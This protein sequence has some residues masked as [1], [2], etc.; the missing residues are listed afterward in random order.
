M[1][2]DITPKGGILIQDKK[3]KKVFSS[4]RE[5]NTYIDG[6]G[7]DITV[8]D[9]KGGW[10]LPGLIDSHSHI[11]ITEDKIGE[12]GNDCNE[13]VDPITPY[14]SALDG[15]NPM[16]HAFDSAIRAG[17]T[18]V[19]V[20]P[21]S[22]NVVGGQFVFIKTYGTVVD[23][24]VVLAPAAMK[25]AFGE[26]PK[27]N[28]ARLDKSPIT[29]MATAAILRGEIIKAIQY[30]EK[31]EHAKAEEKEFSID[32]RYEC[33]IPVLEKKIPLK[34]HAHR[35]DDILTAIRIAK[36]FDLDM[37]LEHCTEA[38]TIAKKIKEAGF[39]ANVGPGLLPR[40]KQE[41]RN[42]GFKVPGQ[43]EKEGVFFSLTTDHPVCP[44]QML[45]ISA[46]LSVREG[47]SMDYALRAI[48]VN[49]ARICRVEHRVGS[50]R[51]GLD[52]D[53]AIFDG[54]PLSTL[55]QTLYTIIDGEV[56]YRSEDNG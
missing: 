25:V 16:D 12:I 27:E 45:P 39:P 2:S 50:L 43:L 34:A 32:F 10:I 5:I 24:M 26:N 37:T 42:A 8:I 46:G 20:G 40:F 3:I 35:S 28:F 22:S 21:G 4:E 31:K 51:E 17:I 29:R 47:L 53:I 56:V 49:A 14:L 38:G 7:K 30:K 11:G 1:I 36:E 18:S 48:T 19:M 55:T 15:I 6:K 33:W 44:I 13:S 9:A 23:D 54:N 52:A 41:L